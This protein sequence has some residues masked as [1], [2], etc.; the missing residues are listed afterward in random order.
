MECDVIPAS[1]S[2]IRTGPWERKRKETRAVQGFFGAQF[3]ERKWAEASKSTQTQVIRIYM[4]CTVLPIYCR[5][6]TGRSEGHLL[7]MS[8]LPDDASRLKGRVSTF[9]TCFLVYLRCEKMYVGIYTTPYLCARP[10]APSQRAQPTCNT[11]DII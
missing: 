4:Y 7:G 3:Q 8:R 2:S 1:A 6:E 9:Y 5:E 11:E 10:F